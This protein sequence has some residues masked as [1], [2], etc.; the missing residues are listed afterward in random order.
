MRY[1]GIRDQPRGRALPARGVTSP[2]GHVGAPRIVGGSPRGRLLAPWGDDM[3]TDGA[4]VFSL[5]MSDSP[6]PPPPRSP[7]DPA[8]ASQAAGEG[9]PDWD[10]LARHLEGS[11]PRDERA[12]V[13]AW[14]SANADDAAVLAAL[15]QTL[16]QWGRDEAAQPTIDV[17]GALAAVTARRDAEPASS[18]ARPALTVVRGSGPRALPRWIG[19]AAGLAAAAALG[20]VTLRTPPADAPQVAGTPTTHRTG[21]G[22]RDSVRLADGT[23]VILAPGSR[24]TV[25]PAYGRTTRAVSL[26][27]EAWFDVVHDDARPFSVWAR[28]VIVRDIG[29]RFTVRAVTSAPVRVVV[30]EG[31]VGV[32]PTPVADEVRLNAG[33]VA[34]IPSVGTPSFAR[35]AAT[36]ADTAWLQDRLVFAEAPMTEVTAALGRWYGIVLVAG[37]STIARRHLTATFAGESHRRVLELLSLALGARVEQRGDTVILRT[38]R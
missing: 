37:D 5:H 34:S 4:I 13:E 7:V 32:R 26:E 21:I 36:E 15:D 24:L 1:R 14:L 29:T 19:W 11:A 38:E 22:V 6:A 33:D 2:R 10:A 20:F 27:G 16:R 3:G 12:R 9:P 35:R 18:A 31:A 23:R 28:D 30:T 17:E 8:P 25:D